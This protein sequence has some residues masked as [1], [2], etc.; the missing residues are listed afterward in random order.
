MEDALCRKESEMLAALGRVDALK[1]RLQVG[2]ECT[3][4]WTMKPPTTF[5]E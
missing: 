4:F 1:L 5:G 2:G 3:I